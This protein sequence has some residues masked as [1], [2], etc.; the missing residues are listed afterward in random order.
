MNGKL[1][2]F[3]MGSGLLSAYGC[4]KSLEPQTK[5]NV[6]D[7]QA[8]FV[9]KSSAFANNAPMPAK[10]TCDGAN[11]S[12]PLEWSNIPKGT[13]SF[14]LVC[15]DPDAP[16]GTFTHWIV[17]NIPPTMTK[18]GENLAKTGESKSGIRQGK[19]DFGKIGFGGPCPP[20]G[21]P[22]RYQFQL[23]ALK[24]K[25]TLKAGASLSQLEAAIGENR[26]GEAE[27]IGTYQKK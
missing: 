4:A 26:L 22:H 3:V 6:P 27:I 5:P 12:P 10:Y 23:S 15:L 18:L 9:I 2:I 1:L 14:V 24:T 25:L 16:S 13:K 19:N 11:L 20:V 7:N 21:K 8:A 17:Y